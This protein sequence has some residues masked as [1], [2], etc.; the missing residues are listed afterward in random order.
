MLSHSVMP[1]S[2]QL[3]GHGI[4]QAKILEWVAISY[5]RES[6]QPRDQICITCIGRWILYHCII[7][8]AQNGS[9]GSY[10]I[11]LLL[12]SSYASVPVKILILR[13]IG[14]TAALWNSR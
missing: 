3:H 14:S 12:P 5:S 9:L 2:L 1:N 13:D 11:P 7:W 8:E 4:F 10:K 6:S